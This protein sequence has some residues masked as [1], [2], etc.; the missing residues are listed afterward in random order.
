MILFSG[1]DLLAPALTNI[2]T[3]DLSAC[4]DGLGLSDVCID[5]FLDNSDKILGEESLVP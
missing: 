4:A 3:W 1:C 2:A 5:L